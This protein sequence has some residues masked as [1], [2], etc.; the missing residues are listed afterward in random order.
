MK[1][2]AGRG[3]AESTS[4]MLYCG[5][6]LLALAG[7]SSAA[8]AQEVSSAASA[9]G[10]PSTPAAQES[11]A[12]ALGGDDAIVVTARRRDERLIDV[13]V[14][15][16]VVGNEALETQ[17]IKATNQLAQLVPGVTV[18]MNSGWMQP[19]IRGI[20]SLGSSLGVPSNVAMYIDGIYIE[21]QVAAKMD[22]PDVDRVEI[23]KGPQGT[24]FGRNATAGAI[25]IFTKGPSFNPEFS[26][27]ASYGSFKNWTV[28]GFASGPIVDDVLAASLSGYF[29]KG[30]G[31]NKDIV[32]G[33]DLGGI[34]TQVLRGKLLFTPGENF[35][36]R[37][38]IAYS[39]REDTASNVDQPYAFDR[40]WITRD[41]DAANLISTTP[42]RLSQ[43]YD[44]Y[45]TMKDLRISL[46]N[47]LTL[48]FG[49]LSSLTAYAYSK[50][51]FGRDID[52]TASVLFPYRYDIQQRSRMISEELTFVGDPI[53]RLD[54]TIGV[55]LFKARDWRPAYSVSTTPVQAISTYANVDTRAFAV[56]GEAYY[57]ITDRL[58]ATFGL[59]YSY[60]K[61]EHL[62]RNNL[63]QFISVAK[64]WNDVSPRASLAYEIDDRTNVY[65]TYSRGFKSG[66]FNAL[67]FS[68]K[69]YDPETLTMYEVGFKTSTPI[70]S[71]NLSAFVYKYDGIQF[72][73]TIRTATGVSTSVNN[74][75][76][77]ELMGIDFDGVLRPTSN[78]RIGLNFTYEPKAKYTS[79]P[80]AAYN[81]PTPIP[82]LVNGGC[83]LAFTAP[84][85]PLGV[86]GDFSGGRMIRAPKL[87]GNLSSEVT[88]DDVFGG[89]LMLNGAV[90]YSS[91]IN[92]TLDGGVHQKPYATVSAT[93]SWKPANSGFRISVSGFNLTDKAAIAGFADVVFSQN[94]TYLRPRSYR[95]TL[96][97]AF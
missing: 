31:F 65:A 53:G 86:I 23:S 52:G 14:T 64:D 24:L 82:G 68:S 36:S 48:P 45:S 41:P 84:C 73:S 2:K 25:Q 39:R 74:A 15:V 57:A 26:T 95:I 60:E 37:F 43:S 62:A 81:A 13:P 3:V 12:P 30:D 18:T 27:Q 56:F 17:G 89:E 70:Y 4:S 21:D 90:Y 44:P 97:Y 54:Y 10:V 63:P 46:K 77:A 20:S 32:T 8:A 49:T 76:G 87:S 9:Q 6:A 33:E 67:S 92:Y 61:Q 29:E 75:A 34:K 38:Y 47:D 50:L 16:N 58:K 88:F 69:A 1:N 72:A 80:N 55:F 51:N 71:L 85:G 91:R 7:A 42:Y 66:G 83:P 22:L 5:V 93:A 78:T 19:G 96:D 35:S 11:S 40:T 28:S 79:F 59:R 94:V